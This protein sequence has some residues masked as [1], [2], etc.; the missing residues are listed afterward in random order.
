MLPVDA[1]HF[2][3]L[4]PPNPACCRKGLAFV[5]SEMLPVDVKHFAWFVPPSLRIPLKVSRVKLS[6]SD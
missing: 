2:A 6:S 4:V 5:F 1:K 3:W